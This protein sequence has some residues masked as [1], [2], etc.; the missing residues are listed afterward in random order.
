MSLFVS[1]RDFREYLGTTGDS[2]DSLLEACLR[3]AQREI[4]NYCHRSSDWTGFETSTGTRY[5]KADSVVDLPVGS[6]YSV[7][8][9]KSWDQWGGTSRSQ[10]TAAVLWLGDA[11]LLSVDSLTNGD[12][13]SISSTSYWLEPRNKK[14]YRYIRLKSD[15]SWVFNT[16]GEISVAGSWGYSTGPD[17]DLKDFV[18]QT[19]RYKLDLRSSAVFDV[20][21]SPEIGVIT[22]PKGI[23]ANVKLGLG[24]GGYRRSLR[25]Y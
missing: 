14:P 16:D 5:Y 25:V 22:V 9:G 24:Q 19:A 15:E 23:P 4:L 18:K 11:D 8:G 7:A 3:A 2:K 12:G 21:A 6:V 20:T 13:T 17:D 10:G 1:I